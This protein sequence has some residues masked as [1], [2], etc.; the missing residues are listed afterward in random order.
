MASIEDDRRWVVEQYKAN[1]GRNPTPQELEG[2]AAKLQGG[3]PRE[4]LAKELDRF[5]DVE[6]WVTRQFKELY[7]R[8]PSAKE[9]ATFT[10][11]VRNGEA[12]R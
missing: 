3:Y 6:G 9:L 11:A 7:G 5:G 10:A 2:A 4:A 12:S 1:E 8:P